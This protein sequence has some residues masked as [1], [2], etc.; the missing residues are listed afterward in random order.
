M[1]R[2]LLVINAA[3]LLTNVFVTFS[4][5]DV[6]VA[7]LAAQARLGGSSPARR[8]A[9]SDPASAFLRVM[10]SLERVLPREK[11]EQLTP[12]Q[13]GSIY[14]AVAQHG[15][16]ASDGAARILGEASGSGLKSATDE[17][18]KAVRAQVEAVLTESFRDP[19]VVSRLTAEVLNSVR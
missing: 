19:D 12:K 11:L 5:A 17:A 8:N 3:I 10:Q 18:G 13:V 16:A 9:A 15:V 14:D 6:Q 2:V 7:G 1:Q 4:A